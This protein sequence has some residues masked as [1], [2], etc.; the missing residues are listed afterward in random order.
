MEE[1]LVESQQND[2]LNE[3]NDSYIK[4][5]K[6]KSIVLFSIVTAIILALSALVI[7]FSFMKVNTRPTTIAEP[8]KFTVT[9]DQKS[10]IMDPT[11]E[12]YDD[13]YKLYLDSFDTTYMTALFTNSLGAYQITET[14]DN[15]YS[16]Y[17]DGVG[18]GRSSKLSNALGSEY[19]HLY[20][21]TE[22]TL[23]DAKGNVYYSTR[24]TANYELNYVDVYFPLSS[25]N[26]LDD[27]TFYIGT[28]GY[29]KTPRI[30]TIT[31]KANMYDLYKFVKSL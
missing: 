30:T 21:S 29:S 5:K 15:F 4:R 22:Q 11:E 31:V 17:S 27:V 28:Y 14:T 10:V 25:V 24:N 23:H 19:V 7:T 20:Y 13:F 16:S 12:K 3:I 18:S 26:K 2:I 8:T 9:T 1:Q 6:V